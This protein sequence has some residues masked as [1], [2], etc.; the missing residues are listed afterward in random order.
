MPYCWSNRCNFHEQ[1]VCYMDHI[2]KMHLFALYTSLKSN[3]ACLLNEMVD[4][5][6]DVANHYP[7][8]TWLSHILP[9][10]KNTFVSQVLKLTLFIKGCSH[11]SDNNH[12][13][14]L[15]NKAAH[16]CSLTVDKASQL[17]NIPDLCA[18]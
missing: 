7:E 14:F 8:G 2:E 3:S 13:A 10:N 15:V 18:A 6:S 12:A 17:F 5:V 9:P 4:V 1:C 11:L 16:V